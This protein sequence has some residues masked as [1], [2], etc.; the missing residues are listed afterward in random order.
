[1]AGYEARGATRV[2]DVLYERL[3]WEFVVFEPADAGVRITIQGVARAT[4]VMLIE[5]DDHL[6]L[7][8]RA[9]ESLSSFRVVLEQAGD[10]G[11]VL[12]ERSV[13]A[14][15]GLRPGDLP[16]VATDDPTNPALPEVFL[17]E[18]GDRL[19]LV[20]DLDAARVA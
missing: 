4:D 17:H 11:C 2:G 1:M 14:A 6:E 19:V 13:A 5:D 8:G 9:S 15:Y 18:R 16:I 12:G 3:D 10:S 7:V 20:G